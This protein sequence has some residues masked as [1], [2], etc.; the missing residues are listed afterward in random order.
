MVLSTTSRPRGHCDTGLSQ[1]PPAHHPAL[2][3][4][5]DVGWDPRGQLRHLLLFPTPILHH[6]GGNPALGSDL[7]HLLNAP[8]SHYTPPHS[9]IASISATYPPARLQCQ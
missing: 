8:F 7:I 2:V 4:Q 9:L 6:P 1:T 5:K 3:T